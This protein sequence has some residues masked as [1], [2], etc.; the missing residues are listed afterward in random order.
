M[1]ISVTEKYYAVFKA[2]QILLYNG[3]DTIPL[4]NY[5]EIRQKLSV[6][7]ESIYIEDTDDLRS[8]VFPLSGTSSEAN[9]RSRPVDA[10][11]LSPTSKWK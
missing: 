6:K 1:F 11:K 3:S 9:W 7:L 4:S 8:G 10:N 5:K 2:D